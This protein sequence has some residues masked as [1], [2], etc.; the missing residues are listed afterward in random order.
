MEGIGD[1]ATSWRIK[2]SSSI[3]FA[4]AKSFG[5]S[6]FYHISNVPPSGNMYSTYLHWKLLAPLHVL[7]LLLAYVCICC[8]SNLLILSNHVCV[9]WFAH[10]VHVF[11]CWAFIASYMYLSWLFWDF[12]GLF[13]FGG[14]LS[15]G[16]L[17]ILKMCVHE[18]YHLVLI[19]RLSSLY[20][21][22]HDHEKFKFYNDH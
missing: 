6:C 9:C 20:V 11:L 22:W 10:H 3:I 7:A 18:E 13:H 14:V 19:L 1:L 21:V 12:N 2:G 5:L 17:T 16:H 15:F 8:A 4:Q